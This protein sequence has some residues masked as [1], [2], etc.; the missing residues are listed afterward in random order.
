M[1]S[2]PVVMQEKTKEYYPKISW[3]KEER[4]RETDK[5]ERQVFKTTK[6]V[7]TMARVMRPTGQFFIK[8]RIAAVTVYA[9]LLLS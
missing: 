2:P 1:V 9:C 8:Q 6:I 3:W 5:T 7:Q 4:R